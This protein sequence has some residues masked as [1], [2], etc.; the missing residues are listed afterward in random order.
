[1]LSQE[2]KPNSKLGTMSNIADRKNPLHWFPCNLGPSLSSH[3]NHIKVEKSLNIAG[4][5]FSSV[6]DIIKDNSKFL[7]TS[8]IPYQL[9]A[10]GR[11]VQCSK[12]VLAPEINSQTLKNLT[13]VFY[14]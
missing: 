13:S 11:R 5:Q 3:T 9:A 12:Y 6:K 8:M 4:T 7:S 2:V 1:M 10:T 14:F